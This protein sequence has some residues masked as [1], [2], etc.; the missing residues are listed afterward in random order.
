M[1]VDKQAREKTPPPN[2][3]RA[4]DRGRER[5]REETYAGL[6]HT[7]RAGEPPRSRSQSLLEARPENHQPTFA[8]RATHKERQLARWRRSK[9]CAFTFAAQCPVTQLKGRRD[10]VCARARVW[11][12]FT[13]YRENCIIAQPSSLLFLAGV[14]HLLGLSSTLG[15]WLLRTSAVRA[16]PASSSPSTFPSSA[17]E[18]VVGAQPR[19]D[20]TAMRGAHLPAAGHPGDSRAG[21][22]VH[23]EAHLIVKS[24]R[25]HYAL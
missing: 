18:V 8:A 7:A 23:G 11:S 9:D 13:R 6:R 3:Q 25:I 14:S 15:F 22:G 12:A 21:F 10:C 19:R 16:A 1:A 2:S 24:D 20:V 17:F 5:K 4:R